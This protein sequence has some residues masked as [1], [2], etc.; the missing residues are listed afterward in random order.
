MQ[1]KF[2]RLL[3][4]KPPDQKIERSGYPLPPIR[5]SARVLQATLPR[6]QVVNRFY[7]L[8]DRVLDKLFD[9]ANIPK[10]TEEEAE[11]FQ[12]AERWGKTLF[13]AWTI[14]CVWGGLL[15]VVSGVVLALWDFFWGGVVGLLGCIVFLAPSKRID[16]DYLWAFGGKRNKQK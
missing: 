1:N 16:R 2:S 11:R 6:R 14:V 9:L 10:V 5:L 4:D 13:P 3:L 7:R 8:L 12:M 15:L